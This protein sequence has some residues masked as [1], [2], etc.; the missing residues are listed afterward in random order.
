MANAPALTCGDSVIV[1][2]QSP[3]GTFA[4]IY[5]EHHEQALAFGWRPGTT[6]FESIDLLKEIEP[7]AEDAYPIRLKWITP[8]ILKADCGRDASHELVF[9]FN[10]KDDKPWK[11][12]FRGDAPPGQ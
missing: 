1:A 7:P 10:P 12:L 5:G 6:K 2:P 8:Q 3:S 4:V 11:L 9:Q